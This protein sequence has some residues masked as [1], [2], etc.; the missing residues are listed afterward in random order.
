MDSVWTALLVH[1]DSGHKVEAEKCQIHQII[2]CQRFLLQMGVYTTKAL[3]AASARA[4][5]FRIWD[6]NLMVVANHD[7]GGASSAVN[8]HAYLTADLKRQLAK[9]LA[10]FWRDDIGG[11]RFATIEVFKAADLASF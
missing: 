4:I 9:G 3:E 1:G 7:V 11:W 5:L 10:E 2:V 8:Q 6:Y